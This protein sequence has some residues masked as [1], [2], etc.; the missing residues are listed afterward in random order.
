MANTLWH[1]TL[2]NAHEG[3]QGIVWT[4]QMV[5]EKVWCPGI[6][7]QGET[8]VKA[9]IPCQS[10]ADKPN[11]EPLQLTVMPDRPYQEV[12]V[13]LC[14]PFCSGENLLVCED[15]CTHWPEVAIL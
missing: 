13:D 4:K 7:H 12:H 3:H 5:R 1:T 14:G 6:V 2:S 9:C 11:A 15:E 10:V 8:M